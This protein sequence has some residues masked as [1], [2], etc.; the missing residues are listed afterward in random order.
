MGDRPL[1]VPP[2]AA[3]IPFSDLTGRLST[4]PRSQQTLLIGIDGPGGAGKTR[5]AGR[6][7]AALE[8]ALH[9]VRIVPMD[10]FFHPSALRLAAA[11]SPRLAGDEYDWRRVIN[12]LLAPLRYDREAAYQRYD[13]RADSLA[14]W[15]RI[16]PG[17]AVIL[18]GV[19]SMHSELSG[20]YD[21]RVGLDCPREIRL[22]RG[23]ERDGDAWRTRWTNEW[24]PAEDEYIRSSRPRDRADL[25]V[26]G[27]G[28]SGLDS[29]AKFL[30]VQE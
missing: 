16:L 12:Q 22:S 26:D 17:G 18:E 20:Y 10:D 2:S 5:F 23:L 8:A 4:M 30:A 13:W 21:F 29:D 27:S 1:I 25:R 6:L 11:F 14:E 28:R 9:P 3:G 24:M 15:H 19:Y 7:A